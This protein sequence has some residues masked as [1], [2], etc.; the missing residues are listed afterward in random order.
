MI[1]N[2]FYN[3]QRITDPAYFFGRRQEVE[4]LFSA[5]VTHQC[6]SLVGERK[7]GKS[8]LLTYI[9]HPDAMRKYNMDPEK[10]LVLYFDLEG[11]VSAGPDEFWIE[12][13]DR[14]LSRLPDGDLAISVQRL[15][16]A[17]EIRFMAVRRLLRRV[18]DAGYDI[19]LCLDEFEAMA[20][21]PRFETDFYGEMRSL[22]GE[23]GLTYITASKRSLYEITFQHSDTLSSPFFNIFSELPL[24]LLHEADARQ[25]LQELSGR[26]GPALCEEEIQ[27]AFALA[28]LHPFFLQIAGYHLFDTPGCGQPRSEEGYIQVRKRFLAEAEDHY[29]YLYSQLTNTLQVAITHLDSATEP[30]LRAL[31]VKALVHEHDGQYEPF[32]ETFREF[33]ERKRSEQGEEQRTM[34]NPAGPASQPTNSSTDLTGKTLGGYRVV[35]PIG[36]GGMAEVYKG[37][38]AALD[39]TVALKILSPRFSAD[40][41][42]TERFQREATAVARLRHPNI[43]GIFDFGTVEA[44]TYMVMEF[45]SGPTLKE[46]VREFRG[47]GQ[48][49]APKEVLAITYGVASALDHAHA[50]GLIHRDVKP[51]NILL[52]L[53]EA[54]K[55]SSDNLSLSHYAV[56]TDFGV[57]KM[58]QGVQFTATGMTLGTPDY[59][60]PEQARGGDISPATDIY[61]LGVVVYEMLTGQ[62]PFS[63]DTPLAVLLKHIGEPPP[64]PR[65]IVPGLPGKVDDVLVKALA[66]A[67]EERYKTAMDLAKALEAAFV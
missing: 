5:I 1:R 40:A 33:L 59:M 19:A 47:Q 37:Y 55:Q 17:G 12:V 36:Q 34:T 16:D 20:S 50:H 41:D 45:I 62:L 38:H 63:A 30:A 43:V 24:N 7:M 42:F 25:I 64:A 67:P 66:K 4:T 49:M 60:A 3:R 2:P 35:C 8:S 10:Q 13:L 58:L 51:A 31:A 61:A 11:M 28:G 22:A 52:R 21:N 15:L 29:R 48:G 54:P 56:L 53:E 39:R 27:L 65:T 18:R 6:R 32:C 23:L 46:R 26:A 14:L 44:V 57:V 9:C